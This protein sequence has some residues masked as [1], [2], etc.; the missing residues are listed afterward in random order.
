MGGGFK[1]TGLSDCALLWMLAKAALVGLGVDEE[2][3]KTKIAPS[4]QGAMR[5]YSWPFP[6][7]RRLGLHGSASE[8]I[9]WSAA[10]LLDDP[11]SDYDAP[12]LRTAYIGG[13]LSASDFGLED[14]DGL[15]HKS[16]SS[17]IAIRTVDACMR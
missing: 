6:K 2:Y 12:N 14:T 16:T 3:V 1:D 15:W 13:H 10:G 7:P 5:I 4:F 11:L 8:S 9:H 17:P